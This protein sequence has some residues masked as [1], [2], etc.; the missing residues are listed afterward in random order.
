MSIVLF[1]S[2]KTTLLQNMLTNN[3]GLRIAVIVNDVASVNIDSKLV[4]GRTAAR[5]TDTEGDELQTYTDDTNVAMALPAGIVQLQNGCACCSISGELLTS[6][7]ELMTLSDMRQD[8]EKFDHI[9]IEMSGVAEPRS[10]RNIF[11]EAMMYDMPLMERVSLDTLVTVIDCSTY[12][13]Y[14]QSSRLANVLESPELFYSNEEDRKKV[15]EDGG[16]M[17]GM[18]SNLVRTLAAM[19]EGGFEGGV[20]DL[21][22]EQTEVADVLVLNKIDIGELEDTKQVVAALNPRAK[23]IA[24]SF[25]KINQ[26]NEILHY[27][28]G[29]GVAMGGVVDDHKDYVAAA[30]AQKCSDPECTDPIHAHSHSHSHH[31]SH[32]D[33]PID[34]QSNDATPC[35]DPDCTDASHSH[36]HAHSSE[37]VGHAGIGTYVYHARRPFH[38]SRLLS[39]LQKLPVVRGVPI[40]QSSDNNDMDIRTKKTFQQVLR[41]KGFCWTADSNIKALYWSHA[42]CSFE[43][44]C[45]GRWWATL[46]KQL[47]SNIVMVCTFLCDTF[48]RGS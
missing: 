25:G 32:D 29:E 28:K 19:D 44:Q 18:S 35:A 9:V 42:G 6:V 41:S 38:P 34:G 36:S 12:R 20:C 48:L 22:V 13:D 27:S 45:L 24:T 31:H 37:V 3:E 26:L 2:G 30:E 1:F 43:M 10:V 46:P 11:Q 15:E 23:I 7:S 16:W 5:G 14:L 17:E 47:V 4:R 39:I 40:G 21:L 8:D 33:D